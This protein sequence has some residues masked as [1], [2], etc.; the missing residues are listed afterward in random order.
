VLL[1]L[2]QVVL[3]L[4]DHPLQRRGARRGTTRHNAVQ[5]SVFLRQPVL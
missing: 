3:E 1:G 4:V 5:P 2:R